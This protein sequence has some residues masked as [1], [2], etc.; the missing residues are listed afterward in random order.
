MT[1]EEALAASN[2]LNDIENFEMF[3]DEIERVLRL[4]LVSPEFDY[5]L[6]LLLQNELARL[7]EALEKL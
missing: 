6:N 3:M 4:D 1:R 2:A 7:N 5:E